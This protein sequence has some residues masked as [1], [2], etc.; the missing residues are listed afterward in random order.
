MKKQC[1]FCKNTIDQRGL[2][3]H[4]VM[5]INKNDK[6]SDPIMDLRITIYNIM[7]VIFKLHTSEEKGGEG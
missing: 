3:N 5:H 2:H 7:R 6:H 1:P 4:L